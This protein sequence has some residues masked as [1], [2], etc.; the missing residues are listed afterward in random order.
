MQK[1][2]SLQPILFDF[3]V[4]SLLNNFLGESIEIYGYGFAIAI[5]ILFTYFYLLKEGAK[6]LG[7]SED[8]VSLLVI[9][10][11]CSS[12]LGG[13]LFLFFQEPALYLND[14]SLFLLNS[15]QGFVFYGALIFAI[16]ALYLF[17]KF[18]SLP[19][20]KTFDL[21]S[22][23]ACLVHFFGR[24]GCLLAGCCHGKPFAG[25]WAITFTHPQ[26]QAPLHQAIH[27]TQIYSM[28]WLLAA[29]LFLHK[30][31]EK[32]K[33]PGFVFF[34]YLILYSIFRFIVEIFRGDAE[35]GFLFNGLF[36]F[37]NLLL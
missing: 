17:I 28:L 23:A 6:S 26:S 2:K 1:E 18:Q 3:K 9:V 8:Q 12:A 19:V 33:V 5:G 25:Q 14:I 15:G 37:L 30:L 29:F 11:I 24:L 27:P 22:P 7:L 4:P 34:S 16:A 31:K 35:R 32:N 13:K 10:V 20:L 21:L 36:L